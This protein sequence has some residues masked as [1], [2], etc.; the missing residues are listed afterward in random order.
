MENDSEKITRD[1]LLF[2]EFIAG[3]SIL[4]LIF[5]IALL[6]PASLAGPGGRQTSSAIT[7]N[8]PWI[9]GAG[10]TLLFYLPPLW[11]GLIIPAGVLFLTALLP[12]ESK[13]R[14]GHTLS[15]I[16][17]GVFLLTGLS[18]TLWGFL[19]VL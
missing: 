8:A 4:L 10:Q 17:L 5:W 14:F 7:V 12:W 18:L 2:K 19:R 13:V 16:L 6:F 11:G 15:L 3:L 9:F 1:Q